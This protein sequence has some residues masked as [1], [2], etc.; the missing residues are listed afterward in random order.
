[1]ILVKLYCPLFKEIWAD[2]PN[3]RMY[4]GDMHQG[5][6]IFITKVVDYCGKPTLGFKLAIQDYLANVCDEAYAA[7]IRN[8]NK[9][10]DAKYNGNIS[11]TRL[12]TVE[13]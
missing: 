8:L 3:L 10:S 6:G 11:W 13:L 9:I 12:N 1:M 7:E 5:D 4:L 2:S